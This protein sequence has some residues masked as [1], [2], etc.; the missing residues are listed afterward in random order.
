MAR[1]DIFSRINSVIKIYR[2]GDALLLLWSLLLR[3][4]IS[5]FFYLGLNVRKKTKRKFF[6]ISNFRRVWMLYSFFWAIPLRLNFI[7]WRLGTLCLFHLHWRCKQEDYNKQKLCTT[8]HLT[9]KHSVHRV[10]VA[11]QIKTWH[12]TFQLLPTGISVQ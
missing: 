5:Q 6:L 3:Y 11:T 4:K 7:C 8:C 12:L 9:H 1:V 2:T 10:A